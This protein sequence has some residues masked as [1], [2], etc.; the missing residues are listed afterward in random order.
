VSDQPA[1]YQQPTSVRLVSERQTRRTQKRSLVLACS[2]GEL[3][4]DLVSQR[5]HVDKCRGDGDVAAEIG[6]LDTRSTRAS[7][8]DGGVQSKLASL[9]RMMLHGVQEQDERSELREMRS[10]LQTSCARKRVGVEREWEYAR[11]SLLE[12]HGARVLGRDA[13][14]PLGRE[15]RLMSFKGLPSEPCP[16]ELLERAGQRAPPGQG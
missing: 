5:G 6:V 1:C 2:S 10:A 13:A 9:R 12:R 15:A 8:R 14:R 3:S 16:S 11:R 4:A 7:A